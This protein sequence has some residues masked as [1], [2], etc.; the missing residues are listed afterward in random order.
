MNHR[1]LALVGKPREKGTRTTDPG[2]GQTK[3]LGLDFSDLDADF[4]GEAKHPVVIYPDIVASGP[5]GQ[6]RWLPTTASNSWPRC[7]KETHQTLASPN[8]HFAIRTPRE[9]TRMLPIILL[10]GSRS[11]VNSLMVPIIG[12]SHHVDSPLK[13]LS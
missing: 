13:K 9:L 7:L 6:V 11:N 8:L 3:S 12:T 10:V 1:L 4:H 2:S 5:A